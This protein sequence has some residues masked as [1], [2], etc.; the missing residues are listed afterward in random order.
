MKLTYKHTLVSCYI[1]FFVQ[2]I[3]NNFSPLLFVTYSKQFDVSL[4]QITLLISY[5]FI[6]QLCVDMIGVKFAHRIGH[7]R[8]MII[9]HFTSF[10]GM[11]G[12]AVFT[13]VMPPYIGLFLATTF[14]ALG[15]GFIEVIASP[16]VEALPLGEKSSTMSLLHSAYCW[17]HL[18]IVIVATLFFM[19]AGVENWKVLAVIW[20]LIPLFNCIAFI[21]VP[22]GKLEADSSNQGSFW[23]IFKLKN[24][25]LFLVLM[26]CAGAMEIGLAQWSS[27]FAEVGLGVSKTMGDLLGPCM[28]ALMM[29]IAR[30][31]YGVVGQKIDLMKFLTY[32]YVGI[33]FGYM[34]CVFAPHPVLSL[35]G[36]AI[37]GLCVG[38]TWPGTLSTATGRIPLGGTTMFAML[39]LAGDIGCS[40]GPSVIG[41]VADFFGGESGL[42]AGI[43]VATIFPIVAFII[44]N[45][46]KNRDK[47]A[48]M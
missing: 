30:T 41:I 28:Y 38:V 12:L 39:A 13:A 32:C 35:V 33:F 5:N 48:N 31:F 14:C 9:A 24:F 27:L 8:G 37:A 23:R 17:G 26:I 3:V 15:S 25:P 36:C 42:K 18:I 45:I 10:V 47:K 34:L 40:S 22:M 46:L 20:S 44:I 1:C 19:L 43:L 29:A 11:A 7:R 16:T 2:A 6:V 21:F 4:E